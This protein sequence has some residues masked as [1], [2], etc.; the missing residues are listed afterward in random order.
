MLGMWPVGSD[1]AQYRCWGS[2]LA[3]FLG[4]HVHTSVQVHLRLHHCF[5]DAGVLGQPCAAGRSRLPDLRMS[6]GESR[7]SFA[8]RTSMS[9]S[10]RFL[11]SLQSRSNG[12]SSATMVE[13]S[14]CTVAYMC[15]SWA[16]LHGEARPVLNPRLS[17]KV[18]CSCAQ[19]RAA[20]AA[21]MED[22]VIS[23]LLGLHRHLDEEGPSRR[24]IE[25]CPWNQ[26]KS[27]KVKKRVDST[28]HLAHIEQ[29]H[30]RG[31]SGEVGELLCFTSLPLFLGSTTCASFSS[32][33]LLKYLPMFWSPPFPTSQP[34]Q[35]CL[36]PAAS[37][38]SC[39][40]RYSCSHTYTCSIKTSSSNLRYCLWFKSSPDAPVWLRTPEHGAPPP[41]K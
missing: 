12:T 41:S 20:L 1:R 19:C 34:S 37:S 38:Y 22:Q 7:T 14:A 26:Q 27:S 36:D 17:E 8:P 10:E 3:L 5:R 29:T 16:K 30:V 6:S 24:S 23:Q 9:S 11:T 18:A 4:I 32:E 39:R 40:S 15:L 35:P 25:G 2:R 21:A 13:S 33:C 31:S 28:W